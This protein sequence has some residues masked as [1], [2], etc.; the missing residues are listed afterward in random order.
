MRTVGLVIVM[1][2]GCDAGSGDD[3]APGTTSSGTTSSAQ[4][5]SSGEASSA[6]S[7]STGE[8]EDPLP[9]TSSG[10]FTTGMPPGD[11]SSS[12]G[13]SLPEGPGCSVQV[14][15]HG[16]LTDPLPRG[17]IENAFPPEIAD[18]LE[19]WC[20]CHT[21]ESNAQNVEH[22]GLHPPGNTLFQSFEDISRP[23]DGGTLGE[24]MAQSVQEYGMPP[25]SCSF[26]S[27]SQDLLEAWFAA[28]FPDG[29]NFA[30]R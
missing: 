30:P 14:A 25:G 7:S 8:D 28:G 15:T 22:P 17:D 13:E 20:G 6:A 19:D 9:M 10:P 1:L 16:A 2:F 23:H 5:T 12:S 27:E 26:P 18:A 11:G 29:A 4:S 21:V 24:A 3:D